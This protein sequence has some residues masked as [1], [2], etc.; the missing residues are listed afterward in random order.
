MM[1]KKVLLGAVV[2]A[3]LVGFDASARVAKIVKIV[4]NTRNTVAVVNLENTRQSF[5]IAPNTA[6]DLVANPV[7]GFAATI[8]V[9]WGRGKGTQIG[10]WELWQKQ[11]DWE[12]LYVNNVKKGFGGFA[13][14]DIKISVFVNEAGLMIIR[15]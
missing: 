13:S 5:S 9:G 4:N 15:E 3:S 7:P 14:P 2:L 11:S 1:N 6:R 12:H 8:W 10:S